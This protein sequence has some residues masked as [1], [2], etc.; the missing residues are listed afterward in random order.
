VTHNLALIE[1]P[2]YHARITASACVATFTAGSK[3]RCGDCGLALQRGAAAPWEAKTP[4]AKRAAR[5]WVGKGANLPTDQD[6]ILAIRRLMVER[7]VSQ[8]DL[9]LRMGI[10]ATC[11][12][13]YLNRKMPVSAAMRKRFEG[14]L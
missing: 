4:D 12:W 14:A 5:E 6:P 7:G 1:C 2:P 11:V 10:T 8:A 13:K 9:A 3:D